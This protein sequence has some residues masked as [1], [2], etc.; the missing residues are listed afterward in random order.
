MNKPQY[1]DYVKPNDKFWRDN[2]MKILKCWYFED[3]TW[4]IDSWSK[5]GVSDADKKKVER[6]FFRIL[7]KK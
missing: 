3:C 6:E 4:N 1:K 5:Y 7:N 2:L